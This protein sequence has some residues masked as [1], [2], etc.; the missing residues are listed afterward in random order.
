MKK[1]GQKDKKISARPRFR[2]WLFPLGVMVIYLALLWTVPDR[3]GVA[4]QT[5]GQVIYQ[6]ALPLLLAFIFMFLLN[7]FVTPV[8]VAKFLGHGAGIKGILLSSAA[9]I[10]SMGPIFA[11][12]PLLTSLREKG[13]SDFHLANFLS[14]RAVKPVLLP[15]MIVYF[16]WRFSL[17]FT[18]VSILGALL[19]AVVV[20]RLTG[21]CD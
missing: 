7:L 16:G 1:S 20:S 5:C 2:P 13:A 8:H 3:A 11:W 15:M 19:I 12:Y 4:L 9:G 17:V 21:Q 6:S 18:A 14:H 10:I